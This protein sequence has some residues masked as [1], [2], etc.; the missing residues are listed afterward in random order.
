MALPAVTRAVFANRNQIKQFMSEGSRN[1]SLGSRV[2]ARTQ[3]L[4]CLKWTTSQSNAVHA[5]VHGRSPLYR[6]CESNGDENSR[7]TSNWTYT[8]GSV[9][10]K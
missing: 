8:M 5:T 10:G 7:A 2:H 1:L 4:K 9:I 3:S 6:S